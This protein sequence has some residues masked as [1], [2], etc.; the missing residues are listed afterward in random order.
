VQVKSNTT[1][2]INAGVNFS[3]GSL[4]GATVGWGSYTA[5]NVPGGT[6][7][8]LRIDGAGGV[9]TFLNTNISGIAAA[10][11]AMNI[12]NGASATVMGSTIAGGATGLRIEDT[13]PT[14]INNAISGSTNG[15]WVFDTLGA[16][17]PLLSLNSI[18]GGTADIRFNSNAA[19]TIYAENT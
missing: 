16:T 17:T 12:R 7:R 18:N 4:V 11:T 14:I 8:G 1:V 15:V 13:S 3:C 2:Q 10:N 9:K 5:L 19:R 6:W